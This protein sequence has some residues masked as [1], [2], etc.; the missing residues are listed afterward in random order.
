MEDLAAAEAAPVAAFGAPML[1]ADT[2]AAT[3][4]GAR[5][6]ARAVAPGAEGGASFA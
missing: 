6:G 4:L 2:L 5:D 3:W 1:G